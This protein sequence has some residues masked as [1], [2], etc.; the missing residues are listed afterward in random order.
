MLLFL[1]DEN[2]NNHIVRGVLRRNAAIDF[3]RVQDELACRVRDDPTVLE[4]ASS[5]LW[6][7]SAD[8]MM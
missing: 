7:N 6:A 8:I 3:I 1:A 4:W 5:G 2:F